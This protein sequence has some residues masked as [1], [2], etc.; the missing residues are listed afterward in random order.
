MNNPII[1]RE[2]VGLL[3][4]P[5]ALIIQIVFSL[6]LAALL[7]LR[8]PTD[9]HVA[10]TGEQSQQ[11]L[12][13]VSFGMLVGLILLAPV[14][15][16]TSVVRERQKGTLALLL[17][18]PLSPWSILIGKL[19]G[20]LGFILLLLVLSF[21]AAA[22]CYAMGGIDLFRQLAPLYAILA[23]VAIEYAAV[24][25]YIST[26]STSIDAALRW[27]YAA[28]LALALL[29]MGPQQFL[30]GQLTDPL[31]SIITWIRC[32]SPIPA[33]MEIMGL[34]GVGSGGIVTESAIPRTLLLASIITIIL[35]ILTG[36][37]LGQRLL[38]RARDAGKV[39][40]ERT[41]GVKAYRRIM[42]LWFFDPQRRAGNIGPLTNP[43]TV[44][45][46]RT[47]R[48]GRS[49]WMLRLIFACMIISLGL[50]LATTRGSTT[51]GV[52]TLG[53]LMVL[54]Q[55]SL[56][57]LLTPSLAAGVISTERESGGWTL[58]QMTPLS[59]LKIIRGKLYAVF[60]TLAILLVATLP[61]YGVMLLISPAMAPQALRVIITLVLTAVFATLVSAALSSLFKRTAAATAASYSVLLVVTV[62][63]M[64]VWMLRDAPFSFTAVQAALLINPLAAALSAIKTQGFADYHLLPTTWYVLG[65]GS[66]LSLIVLTVQTWRLTRPR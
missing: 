35:L 56:I 29:P 26:R 36:R 4:T 23:L 13:V 2:L 59:P 53:G 20:V 33:V 47:S 28:V 14:F 8:W 24:G 45:E 7:L 66:L 25:L 43:V 46:F 52:E 21:P 3:R 58:L 38:D 16:A 19:V 22:A 9:A 65:G 61:G 60:F 51:W 42:Y 63:T 39:T 31:A 64:L 11:V 37:R 40:D 49:T 18:S 10:L 62:G 1:Q 41:A 34:S 54:L 30:Q 6:V 55:I 48:F 5:A 32:I 57:I 15:P 17:N 27:T 44:K 12:R 50:M